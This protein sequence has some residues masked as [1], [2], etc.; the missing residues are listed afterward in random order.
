MPSEGSL[1]ITLVDEKGEPAQGTADID[2]RHEK[3]ASERLVLKDV[4]ASRPI[5]I[6]H[7]RAAPD[8]LYQLAIDASSFQPIRVIVGIRSDRPT[9]TEIVLRGRKDRRPVEGADLLFGKSWT[10]DK[11]HSI[12]SGDWSPETETRLYEKV[13]EGYKLT[14]RGT[15]KGQPYEWA[16]TAQYD[17]QNH[18][19]HGRPDVDS[20]EAYRVN[21]RITIGFFKKADEPGGPYARKVSPDGREL[22]VQTVGRRDD[23]TIYFDVLRYRSPDA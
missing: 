3:G 10:I 1:L 13:G 4:D 21:D 8:G 14:V 9:E 7:L 16:Y 17:G 2:L 15:H 18:P 11:E 19:V 12:F 22:E 6:E 5:K 20:I 23:G